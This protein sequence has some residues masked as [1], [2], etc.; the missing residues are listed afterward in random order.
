ENLEKKSKAKKASKETTKRKPSVP[1]GPVDP[2]SISLNDYPPLTP[3][4]LSQPINNSFFVPTDRPS[5]SNGSLGRYNTPSTSSFGSTMPSEN[6][7]YHGPYSAYNPSGTGPIDSSS[8]SHGTSS[9]TGSTL[10]PIDNDV[11]DNPYGCSADQMLESIDDLE[12]F[13]GSDDLSP[14]NINVDLFDFDHEEMV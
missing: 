8:I 3:S 13:M 14:E 9:S 11:I 1:T 7:G 6:I 5:T 2:S 12:E 10:R 4:P